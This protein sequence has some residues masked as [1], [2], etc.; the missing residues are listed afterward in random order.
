M[1]VFSCFKLQLSIISFFE[2]LDWIDE[3]PLVCAAPVPCTEQLDLLYSTRVSP[4]RIYLLLKI[5]TFSKAEIIFSGIL[6]P[7]QRLDT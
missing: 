1:S 5:M 4:P 6:D 7:Q 3:E 2:I